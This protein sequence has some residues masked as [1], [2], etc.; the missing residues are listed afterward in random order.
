MRAKRLY[1]VSPRILVEGA[2][3]MNRAERGPI[4]SAEYE[5]THIIATLVCRASS[6]TPL[7]MHLSATT[8]T[9]FSLGYHTAADGRQHTQMS[10]VLG[11]SYKGS[12]H[13][14]AVRHFRRC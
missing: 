8:G 14:L 11:K 13:A 5:T 12:P 7:E 9:S 10:V 3:I 2:H 4:A 1:P 6:P